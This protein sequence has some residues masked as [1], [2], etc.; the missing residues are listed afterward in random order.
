[1]KVVYII[2]WVCLVLSIIV[3]ILSILGPDYIFSG[4]D[5]FVWMLHGIGILLGIP[6]IL[7]AQKLTIGTKEKDFWKAAL[8]EC[9]SWMR[10]M[11]GFFF[12][13]GIVSFIFFI[14]KSEE[15]TSGH[16][17]PASIFKGF[18]GCWMIIYSIE[19]A[20]FHSYLKK[21]FSDVSKNYLGTQVLPMDR[22]SRQECEL[23]REQLQTKKDKYLRIIKA[24]LIVGCAF[25]ILLWLAFKG[26]PWFLGCAM[27]SLF[28][29]FV[30]QMIYFIYSSWRLNVYLQKNHFK[31]WKKSKSYSFADRVEFQR[32][33]K[34]LN[35]PF[36][37]SLTLKGTRFSKICFWIWLILLGLALAGLALLQLYIQSK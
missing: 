18:S 26:Y 35:D 24:F 34:E 3:H 4:V 27:F 28:P 2:A 30:I 11:V 20:I 5:G 19:V 8:K 25:S 6:A 7:S 37:K 23:N 15:T 29:F 36:L 12:L 31:I 9:P 17:T 33:F 1:M 13:Y 16:G 32:M 21:R 22:D 14:T 10:K